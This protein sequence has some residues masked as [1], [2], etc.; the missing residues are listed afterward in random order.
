MYY[1]KEFEDWL[2]ENIEG[3][4]CPTA[5]RYTLCLLVLVPN[6][7]HKEKAYQYKLILDSCRTESSPNIPQKIPPCLW[8]ITIIA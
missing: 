4:I 5:W 1:K 3:D 7:L 6:L 8:F 2:L